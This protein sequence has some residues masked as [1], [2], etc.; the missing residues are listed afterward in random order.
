MKGETERRRRRL[1]RVPA[2]MRVTVYL[3]GRFVGEYRTR[4][5]NRAGLGLRAGPVMLLP[6]LH[7]DVQL[8]SAVAGQAMP[9]RIPAVVTH[10]RSSG[11]GV[12][13]R[14]RG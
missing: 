8:Y 4:D 1:G 13:F 12:A 3:R 6:G 10:C 5:V 7:I 2:D 9:R 14:S 11:M